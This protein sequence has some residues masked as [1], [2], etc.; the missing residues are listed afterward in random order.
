MN[1]DF[2]R[3]VKQGL[4]DSIEPA[5]KFAAVKLNDAK[6]HLGNWMSSPQFLAEIAQGGE[7]AEHATESMEDRFSNYFPRWLNVQ[8]Q[9]D[10]GSHSTQ[11][12]ATQ[13]LY[14]QGIEA[15]MEAIGRIGRGHVK[16]QDIDDEL[17]RALEVR[18]LEAQKKLD[19]VEPKRHYFTLGKDGT[20]EGKALERGIANMFYNEL[21]TDRKSVRR[22]NKGTVKYVYNVL[23]M[24]EP[25]TG[26]GWRS[27]RGYSPNDGELDDFEPQKR[28]ILN[29]LFDKL[30]EVLKRPSPRLK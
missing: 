7:A 11:A 26:L 18:L 14:S 4:R 24:E 16:A 29:P 28:T 19:T 13:Y 30:G 17:G 3:S 23:T 8:E 9:K 1:Y 15:L 6:L 5:K 20:I 21:D 22:W 2:Q 12:Y 10:A 27:A 25:K